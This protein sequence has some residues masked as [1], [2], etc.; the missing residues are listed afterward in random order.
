[1]KRII[2]VGTTGA[3]KTVFAAK[4]ARLLNAPHIELDE[5]SWSPD[6]TPVPTETIIEQVAGLTDEVA[7]VADGNYLQQVGALIWPRADTLVWLD[8]PFHLILRRLLWRTVRR[9]VT[10]EVHCNGNHET[11]GRVFSNE[12]IILW[13]FRTHWHRRRYFLQVMI[14]P[15]YASLQ[16]NRFRSPR[17]TE[18]WLEQFRP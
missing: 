6:W 17:E 2:V 18:R 1:M 16:K 9:T 15:A 14:D 11:W 7:W 4:L 12:S 5:L 3:G 13:A 10:G 8:Y